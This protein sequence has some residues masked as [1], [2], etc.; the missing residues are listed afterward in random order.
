MYFNNC[1]HYSFGFMSSR[2]VRALIILECGTDR[3]IV[4]LCPDG[5]VGQDQRPYTAGQLDSGGLGSRCGLF[6]IDLLC[7]IMCFVCDV[8]MFMFRRGCRAGDNVIYF[9]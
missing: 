7:I 3:I 8:Y 9:S 5:G 2:R 6:G 1:E 4:F